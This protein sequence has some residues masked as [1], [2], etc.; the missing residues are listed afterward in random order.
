MYILLM[1]VHCQYPIILPEIGVFIPEIHRNV[2]KNIKVRIPVPV[3]VFVFSFLV[4]IRI[5]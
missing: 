2:L 3:Q 1:E 5:Q 4:I